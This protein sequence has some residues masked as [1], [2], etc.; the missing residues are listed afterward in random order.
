MRD[1]QEDGRGAARRRNGRVAPIALPVARRPSRAGAPPHEGG[2]RAALW[3]AVGLI[4]LITPAQL[5]AQQEARLD[6]AIRALLEPAARA[7]LAQPVPASARTVAGSI[8]ILRSAAGIEPRLG[9]LL[10]VT[11]PAALAD[12]AAAGA[13]VGAVVGDIATAWVPLSSMS[14]VA[15]VGGVDRI[16]AAR[17]VEA[18]HDSSMRAIR[19]DALRAVDGAGD[20]SGL[21][22][23]GSI[24]GVYDTGLDL[25]HPD[26]REPAGQTRVLALW[27]QF[28]PVLNPPPG[29]SG[30]FVCTRVAIQSRIDT[31]STAACP[32]NDGHGHGT[33]VAGTAAG[34][35]SAGAEP[36]RY[37]GVA[38]EA[39]LLIVNGG[40]GVFFENL[41]IE[42]L[43]WMRDEAESRGLPAAVNLSLG[44][45]YGPHDGSRLYEQAI[46]AL[47]GP[48]FIVAAAAGNDGSNQNTQPQIAEQLIHARAV[49]SGLTPEEFTFEI[50]RP[51]AGGGCATYTQSGDP[52]TGNR[53]ELDMWYGAA[54]RLRI[55][56]IRPNGVGAS[57]E[58]GTSVTHD[59]IGG[60]I[61]ID[62]AAAGPSPLNGEL[63]AIVVLSGCGTSGPP[64]SGTWQIRVTPTAAG[65]G[66]PYDLWIHRASIGAD[67]LARGRAGFDNR[68]IVAS[69]GNATRVVTVGAFATRMCWP[70]DQ[71]FGQVC[72]QR[73]EQIG[74]IAEFSAAGPRRD[75]LEKPE[76]TAPGIGVIS[77]LTSSIVAPA[78]RVVPGGTHWVL[79]GTSM[80]A[81]HVTGAIALLYELR[82]T[83]GP[84]EVKAVLQSSARHD[85][86]TSR[87]YGAVSGDARPEDWWGSGKL[88]VEAAALGLGTGE[89]AVVAVGAAPI[90]PDTASLSRRGSL[91]PLLEVE[92]E[93]R[94]DASVRVLRMGFDVT[95]VDPDARLLMLRDLNGNGTADAADRVL[96]A[97]A[98]PLDG[99][100]TR[101]LLQPDSLRVPGDATTIVLIAL[102]LSG[103]AP[104]GATFSAELVPSTVVSIDEQTLARN[105]IEPLVLAGSGPAETSLLPSDAV[106]AIDANPVLEP[107]L[108]LTFVET[109][110]HAAVYTVAGRLVAD[111]RRRLEPDGRTAVWDLTNDDGSRVAP[112]VYLVVGVVDGATRR[113]KLI[114]LTPGVA[115]AGRPE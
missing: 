54:D 50:C 70:S 12:L 89:A 97:R 43:Q 51:I 99:G 9:V 67:G 61:E 87:V 39:E 104:H 73:Q 5:F 25:F 17:V 94:G 20:W 111:L 45:Q 75:G 15:A 103:A 88:D 7:A 31:G 56:V 58:F 95:G 105:P 115:P 37:A 8:A 78:I 40:P 18:V 112:G 19:V 107:P 35:G 100:E 114:I 71:G 59:D 52:C 44:G 60:R 55:E 85:E 42:G 16:E 79:E 38:P 68:F 65:S 36:Y 108:R 57:A 26:F 1:A 48:G 64:L 53:I 66:Q 13:Q 83:L 49:P 27:D 2:L 33:H 106:F 10:R 21:T 32:Q 14:A 92:I 98:A 84:E 102:E 81:P 62:N 69:P 4:A 110:S 109:P 80:A 34:D 41:I 30:G 3:S 113:E 6:P 96:G 47:S 29:F 24:V 101:V 72:Y 91:L 63:E 76:I 90:A 28:S 82:P 93:N 22:G 86:F 23:A 11:T 46:D 77:S 74:D